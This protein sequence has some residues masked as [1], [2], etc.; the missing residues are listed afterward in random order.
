MN[1]HLIWLIFFSEMI[2]AMFSIQLECQNLGKVLNFHFKKSTEDPGFH[3]GKNENPILRHLISKKK[4][5]Y[6]P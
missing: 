6:L 1:S 2:P 4:G 3:I 5:H